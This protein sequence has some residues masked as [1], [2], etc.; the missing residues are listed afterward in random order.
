MQLLEAVPEQDRDGAMLML[1]GHCLAQVGRT[2]EVEA[3]LV[4]AQRLADGEDEILDAAFAR[5]Q[6]LFWVQGLQAKALDVLGQAARHAHSPSAR[7]R[8]RSAEATIRIAC[9]DP[10]AGL[11]A[12][13]EIEYDVDGPADVYVLLMSLMYRSPGLT[14]TGRTTEAVRTA[15]AAYEVHLKH[16]GRALY[17]HPSAQR[18]GLV[19]ALAEAGRLDE[20]RA[21]GDLALAELLA[22]RAQV[23]HVWTA[24]Q[25]ARAEWLSGH[26]RSARH[27][28]AESAALGRSNGQ[29]LAMRPALC[30][31]AA[32]AAQLDDTEA[33]RK[34]LAEAARYPR[35][36]LFVGEDDL[37]TAWLHVAAG[38]LADA[39]D[40]LTAA[41]AL[42]REA[43]VVSS[44]AAL[45]TDVARL[46]GA[47]EVLPR[48]GELGRNSDSAFAHARADYVAALASGD[49]H[50]LEV[51]SSSFAKMGADLLAAEA[52]AAAAAAWKRAGETRRAT[53][54]AN[55]TSV[56]SARCEDAR[57]PLLATALE[58]AA[59]L[60]A[61]ERDVAL[62]LCSGAS[63]QEVAESLSISRRTVENHVYN[64]YGKLGVSTR[65][66]LKK[67][68]SPQP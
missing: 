8:L 1:L 18:N 64:I 31:L 68:I 26:P 5:V 6:N 30:G 34:A 19:F 51:V 17:L 58:P 66:E 44:E 48:I 40:V 61:R 46:G 43:K 39:R 37:A 2:D 33:A 47:R 12:R 11:D 63:A 50:G 55:R 16:D 7:F 52:S 10:Q 49:A 35:V 38:R 13:G 4:Q 42:A 9:G 29:T 41:A 54:A 56:L 45:L 14:M 27:W 21:T 67:A 57:T 23:P 22:A 59:A 25:M 32:A 24:L 15:E 3:V 65:A 28:Y 36:G 20:A 62:L 60:T 53:A